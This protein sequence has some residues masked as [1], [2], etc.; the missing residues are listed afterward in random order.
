M[1]DEDYGV[2]QVIKKGIEQ[3]SP[4]PPAEVLK[5]AI[6]LGMV[7]GVSENRVKAIFDAVRAGIQPPTPPLC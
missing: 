7:T 5:L 4:I 3:N 6:G 2:W 1:K